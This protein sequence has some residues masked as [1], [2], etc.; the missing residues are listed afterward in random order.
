MNSAT[1][2]T[3]AAVY[4][5]RRITERRNDKAKTNVP[6]M[7]LRKLNRNDSPIW[8]DWC[9]TAESSGISKA[10]RRANRLISANPTAARA[11]AN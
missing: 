1:K 7:S 9:I 5:P 11:V 6:Q 3:T 4:S 8:S 10:G 2:E